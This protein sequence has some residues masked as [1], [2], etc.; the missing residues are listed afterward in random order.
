MKLDVK[1][2]VDVEFDNID[3]NDYPDFCDAYVSQAYW[4][5]GRELTA[6]ELDILNVEHSEY[7]YELLMKDL[8]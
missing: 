2:I 8:Y 5:D 1:R 6:E 4:D 7:V 3:Y